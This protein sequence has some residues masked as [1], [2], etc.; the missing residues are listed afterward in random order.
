MKIFPDL[1]EDWP[2]SLESSKLKIQKQI[3]LTIQARLVDMSTINFT[4]QHSIHT[5]QWEPHL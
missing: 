4:K 3:E 1:T 2:N 5:R